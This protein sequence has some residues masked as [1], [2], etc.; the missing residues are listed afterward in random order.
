[1]STNEANL[2]QPIAFVFTAIS[3]RS[4]TLAPN[5]INAF[6][7]V[8]LFQPPPPCL[9][10]FLHCSLLSIYTIIM[11]YPITINCYASD[12]V[13]IAE[14]KC[15]YLLNVYNYSSHCKEQCLWTVLLWQTNQQLITLVYNYFR[16]FRVPGLHDTN[17]CYYTFISV[18]TK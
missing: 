10:N 13:R 18:Y 12:I 9:R 15:K 1:M 6:N 4:Y 11:S 5:F 8:H 17:T 16:L 2:G 3:R 7:L 14:T